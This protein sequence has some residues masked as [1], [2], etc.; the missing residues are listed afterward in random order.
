[1]R[2][3]L[4]HAYCLG[5]V[6]VFSIIKQ[7]ILLLGDEPALALLTLSAPPPPGAVSFP[8]FALLQDMSQPTIH[9]TRATAQRVE[10]S[11]T[12]IGHA[13]SLV[14]GPA[15]VVWEKQQGIK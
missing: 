3:V 1:M 2:G 15:L 10:T 14:S 13:C 4:T 9:I 8:D 6:A 7:L 12:D 5:F 11:S